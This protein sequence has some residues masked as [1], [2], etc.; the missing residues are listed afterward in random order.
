[1]SEE[2]SSSFLHSRRQGDCVRFRQERPEQQE[3]GLQ[4]RHGNG[5]L[6]RQQETP[7]QQADRERLRQRR[8]E[9]E[10]P[11]QREQRLQA[12]RDRRQLAKKAM[13]NY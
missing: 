2:R 4:D 6:T 1:M 11:E 7:E 3:V 5:R 13:R 12:D 9:Q 8:P 10:S